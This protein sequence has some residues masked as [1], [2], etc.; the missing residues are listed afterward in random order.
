MPCY[1][2]EFRLIFVAFGRYLQKKI[3]NG[4]AAAMRE[5][6][7]F[8]YCAWWRSHSASIGA[9]KLGRWQLTPK[10]IAFPFTPL[11]PT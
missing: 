7:F 11:M 6:V 10:S 4:R 1:T 9:I 8:E 3:Q 5:E 2:N